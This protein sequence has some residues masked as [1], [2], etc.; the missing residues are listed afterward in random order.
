MS[1][2]VAL[3]ILLLASIAACT[4]ACY[5]GYRSGRRRDLLPPPQPTVQRHVYREQAYR[6]GSMRGVQ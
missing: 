4:L 6:V 1:W 3:I 2:Q 5:A